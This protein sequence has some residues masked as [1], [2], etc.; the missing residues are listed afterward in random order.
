M[1]QFD[2]DRDDVTRAVDACGLFDSIDGDLRDEL[3]GRFQGVRLATGD[4]LM[5][6]GES[7]DALYV[8]RHGRLRVSIAS[9]G[10]VDVPVG[11]IGKN[12]VVGE[13]AVI[14]DQDRSATVTALRDTDV[15]RL[16]AQAFG[17]LIQ[18][19]P[20]MLRP[21]ASVV[22][23]RLR[24]AMTMP[25]RPSLPAT[26]VLL[27]SGR[28]DPHAVARALERELGG[29]SVAVLSAADASGRDRPAA[30]LLD[31]ENEVDVSL[32]VADREPT[33]WTRL[34]LRHADRVL[35]LV[36]ERTSTDPTVV[37]VDPGCGARLDEV[38]VELV[39]IHDGQPATSRWLPT[40]AI[41][42]HHNVHRD[43]PADI[44]RVGRRITGRANVVVLGGGGA[45]GFAHFGVV[46]AMRDHGI[47]IDAIVGTSAGAVIGGLLAR[48]DDPHEAAD[49]MF[50]W[51][52]SV[53]WRR[54]FNPPTVSLMSGRTMSE[55]LR[56]LGDGKLIEDLPIDFAAVSCDLVHAGPYVHD[57]GPLWQSL[58]ASGSV[59]GLFPPLAIDGRLLVDGGLVANLPIEIARARHGNSHLIAVEVGDPTDLDLGGLD[60]SG[61]VNGW[62]RFFRRRTGGASLF[63]VMMRLTELGRTESTEQAD[64][65]L[66]P[67]VRGF[68]L[69][70]TK[71]A[72][73]IVERGRQSAEEAI[74]AGVL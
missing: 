16:P 28:D 58:R 17:H 21:F 73:E 62:D 55:G 65:L 61:V 24:T 19:H 42:A 69:L 6:E 10:G 64:V 60:G 27:P 12:E 9:P 18:S 43:N 59:P 52:D 20:E 15:Y 4:V 23:D 68:G 70:E 14:T 40:R 63:R 72:R 5:R 7:A 25:A 53:R 67:D 35:M 51:F 11:E 26:I 45:R 49:E 37:E 31:I 47:E 54:D 2:A 57:R 39:M 13:M 32:L 48:I 1:E 3:V 34:C 74:A 30:W 50:A 41:A 71:R 56:E 66:T 33:D 46:Q 8:V 22:V 38:P 29:H 44:A 36:D